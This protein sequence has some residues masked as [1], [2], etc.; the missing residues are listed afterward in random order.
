[1]APLFGVLCLSEITNS[2]LH[3]FHAPLV[4]V[5]MWAAAAGLG[6]VERFGDALSRGWRRLWRIPPPP[7]ENRRI[8]PERFASSGKSLTADPPPPVVIAAP[9]PVPAP[10]PRDRTRIEIAA[11]WSLLSSVC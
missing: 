5:L 9:Q 2:P 8:A 1:A 4:P 7:E 6:N 11:A 10:P 3:H